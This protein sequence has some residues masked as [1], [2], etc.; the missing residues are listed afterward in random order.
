MKNKLRLSMVLMSLLLAVV[1]MSGCSLLEG[2]YFGYLMDSE[3]KGK[4]E[5]STKDDKQAPSEEKH[6]KD[7]E[8]PAESTQK[9]RISGILVGTDVGGGSRTDTIMFVTY[10]VKSEKVDVVSIPRDTYYYESTHAGAASKKIN[11][12][13]TFEGVE[14]TMKAV[15]TV[16]GIPGQ[17]D[18]YVE[19]DYDGVQNI[20]DSMGGVQVSVP[21]SMTL[22][23]DTVRP[24]YVRPIDP[25]TY[26]FN[27]Q[28]TLAYLRQ[29]KSYPDGDLGR[30]K[31]QQAF[32][33][34]FVGQVGTM[35]VP[36]I[37]KT[38]VQE[39]KTNLSL[40]DAL[41]YGPKVLSLDK[42]KIKMHVIPG[43][44]S[45]QEVDGES[46]SF[47]IRDE[48]GIKTLMNEIMNGNAGN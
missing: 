26:T 40:E 29:R 31:A 13:Y 6:S 14:G 46:L 1:M 25:G 36:S 18:Y 7:E 33:Y 27:G 41:N 35:D 21:Q 12:A 30:V 9:D 42:S 32:L 17:I 19:L 22:V 3:D 20:V 2:S 15:E 48:A 45:Y 16:L 37:I 8:K 44:S 23:D 5:P 34:E 28:D 24:F 4:T 47:F 39:A 38:S 10:D 43:Q 11:A